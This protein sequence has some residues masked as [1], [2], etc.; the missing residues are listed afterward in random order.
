MV[1]SRCEDDIQQVDATTGGDDDDDV[2]MNELLRG[3]KSFK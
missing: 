1:H 3:I 2:W